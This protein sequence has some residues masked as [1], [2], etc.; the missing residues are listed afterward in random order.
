MSQLKNEY[1]FFMDN[2]EEFVKKNLGK[3]LVIKDQKVAGIYNTDQEAYFGA[4]DQG[5]ELGSFLIQ[6][7]LANKEAY[8]QTFHSRVVV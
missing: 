8:K 1:E 3:V 2:H 6:Q 5:L 7:V 4:I